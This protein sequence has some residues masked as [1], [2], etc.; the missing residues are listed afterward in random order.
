MSTLQATKN[1]SMAT[2]AKY[3][4][5]LRVGLD[6]SGNVPPNVSLIPREDAEAIIQE[7]RSALAPA[8]PEVALVFATQLI[9]CYRIKDVVEPQIY[10]NTMASKFA[11]FPE[12]IGAKIVDS[13]TDALKFPPSPADVIDAGNALL[14]ERKAALHAARKHMEAQKSAEDAKAEEA[15]RKDAASEYERDLR[16]KYEAAG[17]EW[18]GIEKASIVNVMMM[19][20]E[21]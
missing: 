21:K 8:S 12:D 9:G 19:G 7:L 13:L 5:V 14:V 20:G 18:P 3:K 6:D 2:T 1:L 15:A 10:V 17:L 16:E 11:K 4:A